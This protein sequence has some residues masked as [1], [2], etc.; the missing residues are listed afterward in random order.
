MANKCKQQ[1][2]PYIIH[3]HQVQSGFLA[4]I[5][6]IG[7]GFRKNTVFT[8]HNTFSGYK[9]HNKVLS[10]IN[11]MFAYR[12]VC[13]SNTSYNEYPHVIKHIKGNRIIAIQNGVDTE[14]IDAIIR[15]NEKQKRD[16]TIFT[17]VAR[18]VPVKNHIFLIDVL[19][20]ASFLKV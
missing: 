10:F 13:V 12:I 4:E 7:S 20:I 14:R 1:N 11:A 2:I 6:M 16:Y 17:Y 19:F 15:T 9:M 5:A 18:F 3:I 8:V